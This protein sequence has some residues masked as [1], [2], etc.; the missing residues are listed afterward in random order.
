M[1]KKF[2][3]AITKVGKLAFE[4][5]LSGNPSL[6]R[7]EVI[8][9]LGP[10]AFDYGL[11][12]GHEDLRLILDETADIY[13]TFPHRSIQ[14]FLG[15]FYFIQMLDQSRSLESL[16]GSD[17]KKPIFMTNPL[18]LHFCVWFLYSDQ[19][20]FNFRNKVKICEILEAEGSNRITSTELQLESIY[21]NYF[22]IDIPRAHQRGDVVCSAY[23]AGI[24]SK[25]QGVKTLAL[26]SGD[27]VDWVLT[28]M[29]LVLKNETCINVCEDCHYDNRWL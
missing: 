11:L 13:V 24:L 12:I 1:A 4:T 19:Q 29:K 9:D 8:T 10:D 22:A 18:F 28:S 15:A 21:V 3:R 17:C 20:Y 5:L 2:V 16:L 7:S 23:F 14:E 6:Q 27:L 26:K 25:C